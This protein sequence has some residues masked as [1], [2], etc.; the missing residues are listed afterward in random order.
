MSYYKKKIL[1]KLIINIDL[2][3]YFKFIKTTTH[4][5]DG[6]L[7]THNYKINKNYQKPRDI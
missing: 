2:F 6:V 4:V 7:L 1:R 3:N 5:S